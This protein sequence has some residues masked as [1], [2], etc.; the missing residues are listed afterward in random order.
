[1]RGDCG[2]LTPEGTQATLVRRARAGTQWRTRRRQVASKAS[3][4][5]PS[6]IDRRGWASLRTENGTSHVRRG[7]RH[8]AQGHEFSEAPSSR[9][10]ETWR[11]A[12]SMRRNSSASKDNRRAHVM[13][14]VRGPKP[15]RSTAVV[16]NSRV[17]LESLEGPSR[18]A[19]RF[20][21]ALSAQQ[22]PTAV[23]VTRMGRDPSSGLGRVGV[24]P[25]DST[26]PAWGS[27]QPRRGG[28]PEL[29]LNTAKSRSPA[30]RRAYPIDRRRG[31][32]LCGG[33]STD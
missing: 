32:I 19:W 30:T 12:S 31:F 33:V 8:H 24:C 14:T 21:S 10:D 16:F 22:S 27:Y 2:G 5:T 25:R 9:I 23:G 13:P 7:S 6:H 29:L 3:P 17:T 26:R 4:A 20:R 28:R 18:V 15:D 1:M 11:A